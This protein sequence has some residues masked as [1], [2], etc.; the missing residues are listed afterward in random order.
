VLLCTSA[1][2]AD[3]VS[4]PDPLNDTPVYARQK[5]LSAHASM[6]GQLAALVG[7]VDADSPL[8]DFLRSLAVP[9][10]GANDDARR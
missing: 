4:V 2:L 1:E 6:L 3:L 9:D 7:P 5:V 8:D 10:L